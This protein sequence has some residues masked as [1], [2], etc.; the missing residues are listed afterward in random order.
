MFPLCRAGVLCPV[1]GLPTQERHRL[2]GVSRARTV[3]VLEGLEP[4]HCEESLT[5]S[6]L[7]S[8]WNR[9]LEW[10]NL[11]INL[12]KCLMEGNSDEGV[13][14][15][16]GTSENGTRKH[17]PLYMWSSIGVS[18]LEGLWSLLLILKTLLGLSL[19]NLL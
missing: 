3:K 19:S 12:Y 11:Y 17:L 1:L 2:P 10:A 4:I 8:L 6:G 15:L 16:S 14:L 7:F 9:S 5:K 18:C 13:K